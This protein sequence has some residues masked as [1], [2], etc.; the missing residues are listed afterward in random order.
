MTTDTPVLATFDDSSPHLTVNR[1][2][3]RAVLLSTSLGAS[4]HK[5]APV[6]AHGFDTDPWTLARVTTVIDQV[7]GVADHPGHVW[8]LL[9]HGPQYRLQGRRDS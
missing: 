1:M 4:F 9:C 6:M 7:I 8:K 2:L 3:S 5:V